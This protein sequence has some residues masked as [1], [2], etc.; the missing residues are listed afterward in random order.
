M[1][2]QLEGNE[3]LSYNS[4]IFICIPSDALFLRA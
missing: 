3:T 4:N 1:F 2:Y